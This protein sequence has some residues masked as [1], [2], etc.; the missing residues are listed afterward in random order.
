ME[1]KT[2]NW[3]RL[4]DFAANRF[5]ITKLGVMKTI[6]KS[7]FVSFIPLLCFVNSGG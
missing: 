5:L 6:K 1:W 2:N 7:F 3:P 4:K